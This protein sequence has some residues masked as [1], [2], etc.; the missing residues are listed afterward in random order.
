MLSDYE[1]IRSQLLNGI[2]QYS[3]L[4][5]LS[6]NRF[7]NMF[8]LHDISRSWNNGDQKIQAVNRCSLQ[9]NPGESLAIQGPSGSG[10]STLLL[11]S[12]G[13]LKPDAGDVRI[14][15]RNL[16]ELTPNQRSEFRA[17]HLGFVFQQFHLIPYLNVLDNV[18]APSMTVPLPD[19]KDRA[20]ELLNQLGM[21]DRKYH[22]PGQ[23]SVGEKQRTALARALLLEPKVIL[24]DEPTGN[25]DRQNTDNVMSTLNQFTESGGVLLLV[26]HDDHAA[27]YAH[28]ILHMI[29]GQLV[30]SEVSA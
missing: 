26:T 3:C 20:I 4:S 19:G 21:S 12:G 25:L 9:L 30:E 29:D 15:D 24:A 14:D 23:L 16:Y 11:I 7:S 18:C 6:H 13:L 1:Q 8:E 27:S 22:R 5:L 28:R 2:S 10:K 17:T